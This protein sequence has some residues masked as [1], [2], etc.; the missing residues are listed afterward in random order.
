MDTILLIIA[1][2][3]YIHENRNSLLEIETL[4]LSLQHRRGS[5][6]NGFLRAFGHCR[7]S[8]I[9]GVTLAAHS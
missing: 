1:W 5:L 6:G 4:V 9:S 2:L 7:D 8:V 3:Y